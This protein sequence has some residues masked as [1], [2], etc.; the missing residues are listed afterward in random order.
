MAE[1][2]SGSENSN[3]INAYHLA[4]LVDDRTAL[5]STAWFLEKKGCKVKVV[6]TLS[7]LLQYCQKSPPQFIFVSFTGENNDIVNYPEGIR[8]KLNIP[9]IAFGESADKITVRRLRAYQGITVMPPVSGHIIFSKLQTERTEIQA[10]INVN[11]KL[12]TFDQASKMVGSRKFEINPEVEKSTSEVA[13][14][15]VDLIL[16][17]N[18]TYSESEKSLFRDLGKSFQEACESALEKHVPVTNIEKLTVI[19]ITSDSISG[20]LVMVMAERE[21]V[22]QALVEALRSKM[23]G[24]NSYIQIN[25]LSTKTLHLE[26]DEVDFKTWTRQHAKF[27]THG[28]HKGKEVMMAF[29]EMEQSVINI[30]PSVDPTMSEIKVNNLTP[31]TKIDFDAYLY[32]ASNNKF[33]M[34]LRDGGKVSD[35]QLKNLKKRNIDSLHIKNEVQDNYRAYVA[36]NHLNSTIVSDTNFPPT[37]K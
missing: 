19:P 31:N 6:T 16:N 24:M 12:G 33:L 10:S 13:F 27:V 15:Q 1:Q 2:R 20:L 29:F 3:T 37:K 17:E 4:F 35:S 21:E 34:Y 9:V 11:T 36:T 30:A 14:D 22:D 26:I 28:N 18:R 8:Q 25:G 7:D 32:L 5:N 23:G